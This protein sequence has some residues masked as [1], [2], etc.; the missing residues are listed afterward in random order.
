LPH[1]VCTPQ[2]APDRLR[3]S[4]YLSSQLSIMYRASLLHKRFVEAQLEILGQ[5]P[6]RLRLNKKYLS[7]SRHKH[8][9]SNHSTTKVT[10]C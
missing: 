2:G 6:L 10:C 8:S 5:P 7:I 9:C 4:P 1:Q 3:V